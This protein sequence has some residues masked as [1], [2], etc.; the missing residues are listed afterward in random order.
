MA[1]TFAINKDKS[2]LKKAFLQCA[3]TDPIKMKIYVLL[4][5]SSIANVTR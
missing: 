1:N 2:T 5:Y 4:D 3:V